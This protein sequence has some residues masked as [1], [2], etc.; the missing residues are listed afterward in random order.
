MDNYASHQE[1]S[2]GC[3]P[4]RLCDEHQQKRRR[5]ILDR[6]TETQDDIR[7][8]TDCTGTTITITITVLRR[9]TKPR[10][11]T[12]LGPQRLAADWQR[13]KFPDKEHR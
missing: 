12:R 2:C 9:N 1:S 7:E 8:R 13:M 5:T 6:M 10:K 4:G 11:Q 3:R